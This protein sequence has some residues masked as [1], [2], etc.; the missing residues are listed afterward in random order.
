MQCVHHY[1]IDQQNNAEC[2]LCGEHRVFDRN[3]MRYNGTHGF[4]PI[5]LSAKN[6]RHEHVSLT[7]YEL[8]E[9]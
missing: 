2:K 3:P 7:L 6:N 8:D 4:F 9:L 5:D 1:L